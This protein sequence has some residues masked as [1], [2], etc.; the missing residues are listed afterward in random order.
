MH[1]DDTGI[2]RVPTRRFQLL[3][4]AVKILDMVMISPKPSV[5]KILTLK[6]MK[7][8]IIGQNVSRHMLYRI[9]YTLYKLFVIIMNKRE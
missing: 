8:M 4:G 1:F 2:V 6:M 7:T 9:I 5:K 3:G